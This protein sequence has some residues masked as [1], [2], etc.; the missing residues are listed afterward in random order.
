MCNLHALI[1]QLEAERKR[2]KEVRGS[3][4]SREERMKN[5]EK[6]FYLKKGRTRIEKQGRLTLFHPLSS[7]HCI[8]IKILSLIFCHFFLVLLSLSLPFSF[9]ISLTIFPLSR[10]SISTSFS[11]LILLFSLP[12]FLLFLYSLSLTLLL[13]RRFESKLHIFAPSLLPLL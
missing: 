4:T 10:F 12:Y 8:F 11:H 2:E 3:G 13:A 7:S 1:T 6:F 5:M 9:S